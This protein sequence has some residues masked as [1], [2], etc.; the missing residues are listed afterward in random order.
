MSK[1][2]SFQPLTVML[3]D[4]ISYSGCGKRFVKIAS[5]WKASRDIRL[6]PYE[7]KQPCHN[8]VVERHIKLVSEAN[9]KVI[10]FQRRDELI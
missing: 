9:L 1:K 7:F 6:V 3:C 4:I 8:Q 10:G 2:L 5:K